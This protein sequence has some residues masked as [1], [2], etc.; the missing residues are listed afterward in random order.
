MT[1]N[2]K[3]QSTRAKVTD[4]VKVIVTD[5]SKSDR[6]ESK[7]QTRVKVTQESNWQLSVKVISDRSKV[8]RDRSKVIRDRGKV[9]SNW[10]SQSV[11]S[12]SDSITMKVSQCQSNSITVKIS[13]W[14]CQSMKFWRISRWLS[15]TTKWQWHICQSKK[16]MYMLKRNKNKRL[17]ATNRKVTAKKKNDSQE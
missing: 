2:S 9:K 10:Q 16:F 8:I 7:W 13:Q 15:A 12:Q 1:D 5:K 3:W 6:Q 14:Q 17:Q 4:R 11:Q